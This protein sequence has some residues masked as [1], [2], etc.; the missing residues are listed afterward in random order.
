MSD[1]PDQKPSGGRD[2]PIKPWTPYVDFGRSLWDSLTRYGQQQQANAEATTG[3]VFDQ[4]EKGLQWME[5]NPS[6]VESWLGPLENTSKVIGSAIEG[7]SPFVWGEGG[8]RPDAPT[9]AQA[10]EAKGVPPGWALAADMLL[11]PDPVGA[12]RLA[13][14]V[15]LMGL[16]FMGFR[17][18]RSLI[19]DAN[20]PLQAAMEWSKLYGSSRGSFPELGPEEHRVI[21]QELRNTARQLLEG[22][23]Q[24]VA[25]TGGMMN[26]ED[27]A[28]LASDLSDV[29]YGSRTPQSVELEDGLATLINQV[30]EAANSGMG[31]TSAEYEALVAPLREFGYDDVTKGL[32]IEDRFGMVSGA[33]PNPG[34]KVDV[35]DTVDQLHDMARMHEIMAEGMEYARSRPVAEVEVPLTRP[36]T[37]YVMTDDPFEV[38]REAPTGDGRSLPGL[39]ENALNASALAN[40]GASGSVIDSSNPLVHAT[41]LD[42]VRD[43]LGSLL[44]DETPLYG[45]DGVLSTPARRVLEMMSALPDEKGALA[46]RILTDYL[47][48]SSP[49]GASASVRMLL[50][51]LLPV[52]EVEYGAQVAKHRAQVVLA[53]A[54]SNPTLLAQY[55]GGP[56]DPVVLAL[57]ALEAVTD[58]ATAIER[59]TGGLYLGGIYQTV[60]ETAYLL[61]RLDDWTTTNRLADEAAAAV[62]SIPP[63]GLQGLMMDLRGRMGMTDDQLL[64]MAKKDPQGFADMVRG[65]FG[66]DLTEADAVAL[67]SYILDSEML[68]PA[69][70]S[71][72]TGADLAELDDMARTAAAEMN[73]TPQQLARLAEEDPATFE[74]RLRQTFSDIDDEGIGKLRAHLADLRDMGDPGM[75]AGALP[76][77]PGAGGSFDVNQAAR[78]LEPFRQSAL[79]RV[80]TPVPEDALSAYEK[81]ARGDPANRSPQEMRDRLLSNVDSGFLASHDIPMVYQREYGLTDD[82]VVRLMDD[83]FGIDE[84]TARS[85][86]QPPPPNT[87]RGG[88]LLGIRGNIAEWINTRPFE[89]TND[90]I[91]RMAPALD[92]VLK[93]QLDGTPITMTEVIQSFVQPGRLTME[94]F[95]ALSDAINLPAYFGFSEKR[96]PGFFPGFDGAN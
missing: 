34:S 49:E 42:L 30:Q 25:P 29:L 51:Q 17:G 37:T 28:Q 36:E 80:G 16:T 94:E 18:L 9:F 64:N 96:P 32:G 47:T 1:Q 52:F 74:Q 78:D 54:Q 73:M 83:L 72:F 13:D 61:S 6:T 63:E 10:L 40:I 53:L 85:S 43:R 39:G 31:L 7:Q 19:P 62:P 67:R 77:D 21:H 8:I 35:M 58:A 55:T 93:W 92:D 44:S 24:F 79:D 15:P 90:V 27:T 76:N 20:D 86:L 82:E 12:G 45:P 23:G 56:K 57:D 26:P 87:A 91:K 81:I 68:D 3:F 88:Q 70:V 59:Q 71:R 5:E 60:D 84:A 66:G 65:V 89:N 41:S 50:D 11:T 2:T 33:G 46:D 22:S 38:V 14:L 95:V 69:A 75:M 4:A 48:T